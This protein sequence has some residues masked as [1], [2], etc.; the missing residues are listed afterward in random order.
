M[1]TFIQPSV[2][3]TQYILKLNYFKGRVNLATN[4]S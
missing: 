1:A 4:F 2:S 3:P